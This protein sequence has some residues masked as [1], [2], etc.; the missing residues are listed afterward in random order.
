LG[1][2]PSC[3]DL[4]QPRNHIVSL[5]C[6]IPDVESLFVDLQFSHVASLL[7]DVVCANDSSL[8]FCVIEYA[9]LWLI[10]P[11]IGDRNEGNWLSYL[12]H[13]RQTSHSWQ[14]LNQPQLVFLFAQVD[15]RIQ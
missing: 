13:Y 5:I 4:Q 15:V 10:F 14:N 1:T 7:L 3:R 9:V 8:S 6:A 12:L 11:M 2:F